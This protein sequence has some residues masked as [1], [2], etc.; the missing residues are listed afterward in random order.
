MLLNNRVRAFFT[1]RPK[2]MEVRSIW[3]RS[4][5]FLLEFLVKITNTFKRRKLL[6][7]EICYIP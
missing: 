5:I 6:I 7:E 2:S 3:N 1:N 4:I